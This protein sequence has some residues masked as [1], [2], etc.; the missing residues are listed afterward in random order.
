MA[1]AQ[2]AEWPFPSPMEVS[3]FALPAIV[4][5]AHGITDVRSF[6]Q[7]GSSLRFRNTNGNAV[8]F[9]I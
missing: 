9:L 2:V 4:D 1:E 7:T 3:V 8:H 6:M 5:I